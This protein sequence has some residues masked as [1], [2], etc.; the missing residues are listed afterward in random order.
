[1]GPAP[2]N[3]AES[4]ASEL[5]SKERE[6][7]TTWQPV[8]HPSTVRGSVTRPLHSCTGSPPAK[9]QALMPSPG[10]ARLSLRAPA[11]G[12]GAASGPPHPGPPASPTSKPLREAAQR[13]CSRPP[14]AA[15][16]SMHSAPR[17][18]I[19][20]SC[21]TP[22]SIPPSRVGRELS[23]WGQR[24]GGWGKQALESPMAPPV[25]GAPGATVSSAVNFPGRGEGGRVEVSE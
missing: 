21:L 23:W 10:A 22:S 16:F 1:M 20:I 13:G 4:L 24:G 17:P 25:C 7:L 3:Q 9:P 6:S 2:R 5:V 14:R 15:M 12:P 18:W 8:S 19:F 11:F